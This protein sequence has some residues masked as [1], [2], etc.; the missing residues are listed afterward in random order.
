[1]ITLPTE[2]ITI[3]LPFANTFQQYRVFEKAITLFIGMILCVGGVT[4]CGALRSLGFNAD[5]SRFHNLLNRDHWNMWLASRILLK[6]LV[7]TFCPITLTFSIDDTIERRRGR[8]IKAKGIFK[9]P[10]GSTLYILRGR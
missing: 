7:D 8:K 3:L 4:V 10:L 2:I 9:D 5:C 1:M 6:L